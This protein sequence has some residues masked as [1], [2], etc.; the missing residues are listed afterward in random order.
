[1]VRGMYSAAA[2]AIV[3]QA[4]I[5]N[6]A[7]NLANVSTAG[8]KQTLLQVESQPT[9]Q[10]YRYQTDPGQVPENRL[11]GVPTQSYVGSM[12]S[13]SQILATP[14]IFQQGQIST[15]GNT[16][17]FALAGPGF[18]A[19]RNPQNNTTSYTR[20]GAFLR[21]STGLLVTASGAE[22][23][24]QGGNPIPLPPQGHIEVDTKGVINVNGVVSGQIGTY[25]FANLQALQAQGSDTYVAP[26]DAGVRAATNTTV[27]QSAEEKSNAD[28]VTSIVG[29]ISNERWFDAN[30]KSI[31][32]QDDA[33]N[34]AITVVG[35]SS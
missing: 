4:A 32:T 12:G 5:D 28:V 26:A 11:P 22:V 25:E 1:L 18:F 8:F 20:D 27:I 9:T 19:I 17:S 21:S 7:N 31:S 35:R 33:T 15:N 16:L 6:I 2:G 14:T 24:D 3:A 34:Q 29:L 30:E 10:L 13:G 23:L